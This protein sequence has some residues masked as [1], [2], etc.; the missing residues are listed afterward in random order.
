MSLCLVWWAELCCVASN[1]LWKFQLKGLKCPLL[2]TLLYPANG[3]YHLGDILSQN[4]TTLTLFPTSRLQNFILPSACYIWKELLMYSTFSVWLLSSKTNYNVSIWFQKMSLLWR[5]FIP[6]I[7][8]L[9][10]KTPQGP[11]ISIPFICFA[12]FLKNNLSELILLGLFF[13]LRDV[14]TFRLSHT[15]RFSFFETLGFCL[16]AKENF[17]FRAFCRCTYES[18]NCLLPSKLKMSCFL[19]DQEYHFT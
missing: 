18:M 13:W 1:S 19:M 17:G 4:I 15:L 10:T 5:N 3:F 14:L 16:A 11:S 9:E 8:L 7:A 2:S 6:S 12:K